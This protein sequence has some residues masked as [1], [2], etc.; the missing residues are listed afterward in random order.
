[1]P[2]DADRL[3][4]AHGAADAAGESARWLIIVESA[5]SD[6]HESLRQGFEH[7]PGVQVIVDRRRTDRRRGA[8]MVQ[9]ERRS[10]QRRRPPPETEVA[11]GKN[12][13]FFLIV[14]R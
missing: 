8:G 11:F 7:D 1:V 3:R 4:P 2:K 9:P 5:R 14:R 12:A 10:E 6:V 13:G